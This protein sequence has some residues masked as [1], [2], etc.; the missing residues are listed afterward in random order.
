MEAMADPK[1]FLEEAIGRIDLGSVLR[2]QARDM[3]KY[4][5]GGDGEPRCPH[6]GNRDLEEDGSCPFPEC[7]VA[8]VMRS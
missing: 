5:S 4:G 6:C 7:V 8:D 3:W 2:D 1:K